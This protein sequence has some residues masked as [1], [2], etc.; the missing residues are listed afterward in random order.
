MYTATSTIVSLKIFYNSVL[1][2]PLP[3]V[4]ETCFVLFPLF[5]M[6]FKGSKHFL[7]SSHCYPYIFEYES[8]LRTFLSVSIFNH[9]IY[10]LPGRDGICKLLLSVF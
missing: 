5:I 10:T 4:Y 9:N 7:V 2:S 6:L 8:N 3:F 1:L